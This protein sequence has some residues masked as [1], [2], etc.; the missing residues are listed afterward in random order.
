MDKNYKGI[1]TKRA[2]LSV[3]STFSFPST[4]VLLSL[5]THD[6]IWNVQQW[7]NNCNSEQTPEWIQVESRSWVSHP[8]WLFGV[9]ENLLQFDD[10]LWGWH[11]CSMCVVVSYLLFE[12]TIPL[13]IHNSLQCQS[14]QIQVLPYKFFFIIRLVVWERAK[15]PEP[16][17]IEN[18]ANV[19]T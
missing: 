16:I 6:S 17:K 7:G 19:I 5:D 1:E 11:Y 4:S 14:Y 9:L 8:Q 2:D 15:N 12:L 10:S 3:T 18:S 13:S